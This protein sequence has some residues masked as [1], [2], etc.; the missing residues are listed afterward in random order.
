MSD[1]TIDSMIL[2][3]PG[4]PDFEARRLALEITRKLAD[5]KWTG[6]PREIPTLRVQVPASAKEN[7]SQLASMI[8]AEMLREIRRAQ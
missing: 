8:V 3:L 6:A 1:L 2:Q 7:P 4:L 5:E